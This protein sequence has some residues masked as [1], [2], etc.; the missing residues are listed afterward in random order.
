MN[1]QYSTT[2]R[3]TKRR[4]CRSSLLLVALSFLVPLPLRQFRSFFYWNSY[5]LEAPFIDLILSKFRE[6]KYFLNRKLAIAPL[7]IWKQIAVNLNKALKQNTKVSVYAISK[8][9]EVIN[10]KKRRE[11]CGTFCFER[12]N[13]RCQLAAASTLLGFRRKLRKKGTTHTTA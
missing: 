12:W 1:R 2:P 3:V 7:S 13:L 4:R 11:R 10:G 9:K 5:T 6:R 8:K